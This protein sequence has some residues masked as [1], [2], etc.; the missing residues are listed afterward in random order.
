MHSS[1]PNTKFLGIALLLVMFTSLHVNG[2]YSAYEWEERDEWMDVSRI[3]QMAGVDKGQTVADIGC[4]EGY[5]SMYLA[6]A[7][8]PT[9]Q[10]LA[11]DISNYRLE[12]LQDHAKK[13]D[14]T[15][16]RT[17]LGTEADPMLPAKTVDIVFV[18]DAYHEMKKPKAMLLHFRNSLK[19]G[20]KIVILEKLK[21][22]VRNKSRKDQTSAHSLG[23]DI[24]RKELESAG[25]KV[26]KEA[27]DLGDWENN[28]KKKIWCL[29][30]EYEST[31]P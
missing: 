31:E 13:R 21:Q 1:A 24:V 8:G 28:P 15:N 26:I 2:Q 16:I 19:P 10:V 14:L 23:P 27:L 22:H 11:E 18:I 25:F 7:V 12:R 20:G 6:E 4:H 29:V 30:G 17:I 9:G 3:M 5:I